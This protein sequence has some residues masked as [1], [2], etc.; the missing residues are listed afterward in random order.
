MEAKLQSLWWNASQA[1]VGLS[2][3]NVTCLVP[4]FWLSKDDYVF[5]WTRG[6]V[7]VCEKNRLEATGEQVLGV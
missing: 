4:G 2:V 6:N 5:G 7:Q 1:S 3:V